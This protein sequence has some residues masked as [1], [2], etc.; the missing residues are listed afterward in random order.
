MSRSSKR[1]IVTKP[2]HR[3]ARRLLLG[4]AVADARCAKLEDV[5]RDGRTGKTGERPQGEI[6]FH[7]LRGGEVVG[8]HRV[9]FLGAH[10]RFEIAH[11]AA[12]RG[13]FAEGALLAASGWPASNRGCTRCSDVLGLE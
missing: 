10:E 5:R 7:A 2:M 3:A 8:E 11:A 4:R 6:G 9:L 13:L 1:I 12:D